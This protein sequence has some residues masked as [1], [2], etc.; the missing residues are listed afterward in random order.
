MHKHAGTHPQEHEEN[1]DNGHDGANAVDNAKGGSGGREEEKGEETASAALLAHADDTAS[2]SPR[3][4]SSKPTRSF[5]ET[6][7]LNDINLQVKPGELVCVYGPT[8]CGKSTLLLSLLGEVRRV[9]GAVEVGETPWGFWV[10]CE[11]EMKWKVWIRSDCIEL[12]YI[13]LGRIAVMAWLVSLLVLVFMYRTSFWVECV[14]VCALTIPTLVKKHSSML[15]FLPYNFC[16][17]I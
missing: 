3:T 2:A 4:I 5:N 9:Q 7:A 12:G 15:L 16:K 1:D 10:G 8:G 6:A 11:G 13:G 17:N 14:C